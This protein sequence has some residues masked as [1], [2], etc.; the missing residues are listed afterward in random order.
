[1][2]RVGG[3]ASCCDQGGEGTFP[4]CLRPLGVAAVDSHSAPGPP[5]HPCGL[6]QPLFSTPEARPHLCPA[7]EHL[8]RQLQVSPAG[9]LALSSGARAPL[10]AG[11][12]R[13]HLRCKKQSSWTWL[14]VTL[15]CLPLSLLLL[16]LMG[17]STLSCPSPPGHWGNWGACGGVF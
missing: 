14:P 7:G 2:A 17:P 4:G 10:T 15:S 1:M 11:T 3:V 16:V 8:H 5:R 9:G 13:K 12:G 6:G